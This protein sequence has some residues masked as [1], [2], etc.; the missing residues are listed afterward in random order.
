PA[1]TAI[2]DKWLPPLPQRTG[3]YLVRT[4]ASTWKS[5]DTSADKAHKATTKRG[6]SASG[7]PE[8]AGRCIA[9]Y[10]VLPS[11]LL[12]II[13]VMP[14]EIIIIFFPVF[15]SLPP[16]EHKDHAVDFT[17]IRI[18]LF[19]CFHIDDDASIDP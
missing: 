19:H 8:I 4:A 17:G 9:R 16:A 2:P 18:H 11:Y 15:C 3:L 1:H 6:S 5:A 14:K 7:I 12:L 10:A 13:H